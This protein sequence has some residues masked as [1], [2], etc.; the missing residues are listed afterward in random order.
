MNKTITIMALAMTIMLLKANVVYSTT[1][2]VVDLDYETNVITISTASGLLYEF[3]DVNE[4]YWFGDL[5]SVTFWNNGTENVTDDIILCH[6]YVGWP[7]LFNEAWHAY[8]RGG[9]S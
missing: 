6:R 8:N 4:E 3:D 7:E 9:E 1:C 5:V 2:I